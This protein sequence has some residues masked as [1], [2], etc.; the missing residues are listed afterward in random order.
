[1]NPEFR[2]TRRPET[3]WFQSKYSQSYIPKQ[4]RVITAGFRESKTGWTL[5]CLPGDF[6]SSL[7]GQQSSS[8]WGTSDLQVEAGKW[9]PPQGK[10]AGEEKGRFFQVTFISHLKCTLQPSTAGMTV[11][12]QDYKGAENFLFPSDLR[13]VV[14]LLQCACVLSRYYKRVES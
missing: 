14:M 1:M 9:G 3:M 6:I 4:A 11:A 7:L 5:L 13:A 10:C 12:P 8:Q 2:L